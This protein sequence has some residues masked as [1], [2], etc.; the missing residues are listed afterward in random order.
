[1]IMATHIRKQKWFTVTSLKKIDMENLIAKVCVIVNAPAE[2]VWN[3]LTDP[4]LIEQ[5]MFGAKVSTS[6]EEG[7]EIKWSG[8]WEGK[9]FEDKGEVVKTVPA[10]ILVYTHFNPLGG[11]ED[12]PENYHTVTIELDAREGSTVVN[13]SQ[14]GNAS[15][16]TKL[17]SEENWFKMLSLLKKLVEHKEH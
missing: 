6:R 10:E 14:D 7:S 13:L 12:K 5:Y 1:M 11:K 8:V 3:A 17:H 4:K 2:K 9:P 15:E 16:N